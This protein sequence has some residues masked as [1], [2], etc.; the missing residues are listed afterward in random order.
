MVSRPT[1]RALFSK[2]HTSFCHHSS[3][4]C[5]SANIRPTNCHS[6]HGPARHP[7]RAGI[8]FIIFHLLD[9]FKTL[10]PTFKVSNLPLPSFAA[11]VPHWTESTAVHQISHCTASPPRTTN[12]PSRSLTQPLNQ[13]RLL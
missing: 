11:I 10:S 3:A 2:P 13:T 9:T 1:L 6:N 7:L 4:L 5:R 12:T 8:I